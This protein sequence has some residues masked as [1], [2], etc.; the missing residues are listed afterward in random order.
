MRFIPNEPALL[1]TTVRRGFQVINDSRQ[2]DKR[3][4]QSTPVR[5]RI[6]AEGLGRLERESS[7]DGD[8]GPEGFSAFRAADVGRSQRGSIRRTLRPLPVNGP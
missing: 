7:S 5:Y 4:P 6:A 2:S 3:Q 1:S 8:A